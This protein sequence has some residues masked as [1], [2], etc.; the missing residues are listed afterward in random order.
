MAFPS[1]TNTFV[2]ATSADA[3][4]VNTNF[5]DI[6]NSL[7]D[8]TKSLNMDAAT[9]GGA[10]V[11]NGAVTL[12]NGSG[13]D[14]TINGSIATDIAIKTTFV[15]DIG[16]AT[17]GLSSIY[18]G[19]DDASAK[20]VRLMAGTMA[21]S[22]TLVLPETVGNA[23]EFL[24]TDG[25]GVTSWVVRSKGVNDI[26][27]LSVATSVDSN[28]LTVTLKSAAGTSLSSVNKGTAVFNSVTASVLDGKT[29]EVDIPADISVIAASGAKAGFVSG[30]TEYLHVYLINNAGTA[31][32]AFSNLRL[33]DGSVHTTVL[34]D[35]SSDSRDVL[36]STTART[37]VAIKLL[38]RIKFS[39]AAAGVWDEAGDEVSLL[40]SERIFRAPTIQ[41][42]TSGTGTY[43]LP[44]GVK[45]IEVEQV[46]GGGAGGSSGSGG[47][48]APT[49]GGA[50]TF[51]GTVVVAN[52]GSGGGAVS[53]QSGGAG[54]TASLSGPSGV[55]VA[56]SRGGGGGQNVVNSRMAGGHGGNSAF[57]GSG[58][59][60][61][62]TGGGGGTDIITGVYVGPGGGSGGY[63][64]AIIASPAATYAY[65]V[66]AAGAIGSAGTNGFA[67]GAGATGMI[68]VREYYQN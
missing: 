30:E 64:K 50:T 46:G 34:A 17:I 43:T 45:Y 9:L 32:V 6:I 28:A 25:A 65:A 55:A 52:G 44:D 18:F 4:E 19:S 42:F 31:E 62:N 14:I 38:G 3:G 33:D 41:K 37:N 7:S 47:G 29:T 35:T 1:V 49:A 23:G 58:G 36:Y 60:G 39:L 48:S 57:G 54:G 56:G 22:Y 21:S 16:A 61:Y 66:G 10:V 53:T 20:T 8:G 11:C 5:S 15:V 40:P 27:N 2:N 13:D 67:G 26:L 12:G 24:Q 51:G 63:A 59:G 68:V